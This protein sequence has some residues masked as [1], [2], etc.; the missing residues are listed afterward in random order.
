MDENFSGIERAVGLTRWFE[1]LKQTFYVSRVKDRDR[2]MFVAG[3]MRDS[4]LTWWNIYVRP[5]GIDAANATPCSE[6]K[7]MVIKKYCP[8]NEAIW[9]GSAEPLPEQQIRETRI[10]RETYLPAM[11]VEK[12]DIIGMNVQEQG[13]K[14]EETRSEGNRNG[15]N[16]GHGNQNGGNY[17]KGDHDWD[18]A[19]GRAFALGEKATKQENNVV[20]EVFPK[21]LPG[22]PPTRQVK[23]NIDFMPEVI[24]I[25]HA[26]YRLAPAEMKE[27]AEQ[28]K[29]LT[30]K[31]FI[32]PISS[33][34]GADEVSFYTLFGAI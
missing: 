6:F 23:F 13:I 33:P 27:L 26:P 12:R 14:A 10:T 30:D 21:D 25:A 31:G 29:E 34:W 19:R 11:V 20:T 16:N 9:P 2:V 24:P 8:Q 17:G 15:R 5:I 3:T 28:L 18:V 4:A 7:Q 22:I 32:R 1:K